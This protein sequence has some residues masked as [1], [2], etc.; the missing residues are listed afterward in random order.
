[1]KPLAV[2]PVDENE[3]SYFAYEYEVESE[4]CSNL[5]DPDSVKCLSQPPLPPYI[6]TPPH[7]TPYQSTSI[8][9]KLPN[10]HCHTRPPN[11]HPHP[12]PEL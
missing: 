8:P 7:H 5:G 9:N 2:M 10:L 1:M 6:P 11:I 4:I 12:K 3:V